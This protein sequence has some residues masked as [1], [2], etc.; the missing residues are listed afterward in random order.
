[1]ILKQVIVAV[2]KGYKGENLCSNLQ[3]NKRLKINK[4]VINHKLPFQKRIFLGNVKMV[5]I[6]ALTMISS[7]TNLYLSSVTISDINTTFNETII[8]LGPY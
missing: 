6:F 2:F 8:S 5:S 1:M 3:L 4:Y 7:S